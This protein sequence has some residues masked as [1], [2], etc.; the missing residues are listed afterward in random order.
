MWGQLPSCWLRGWERHL[1]SSLALPISG[2]SRALAVVPR[3]DFKLSICVVRF[4]EVGNSQYRLNY[5]F[6]DSIVLGGDIRQEE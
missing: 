4:L 6:M 1:I 5:D 2:A 3:I